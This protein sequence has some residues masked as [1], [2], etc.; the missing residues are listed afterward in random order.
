V[1]DAERSDD[2]RSRA[3]LRL[4][5]CHA[6]TECAAAVDAVYTAAG[7]SAIYA[8]SPLQRHLRDVHV[9]TQHVMVGATSSILAGRV[10]LGVESDTST[11]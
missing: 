10:L 9:A 2:L 4:A 6:A 8:T 3:L 5:A 11:L 1:D 7:G